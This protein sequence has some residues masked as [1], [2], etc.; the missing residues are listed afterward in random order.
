MKNATEF[1]ETFATVNCLHQMF[2]SETKIGP[3][4]D[5]MHEFNIKVKITYELSDCCS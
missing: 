4:A 5:Y 1:T 2:K 3:R